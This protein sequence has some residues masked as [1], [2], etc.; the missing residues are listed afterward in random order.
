MGEGKRKQYL[1]LNGK[2]MLQHVIE[3]MFAFGATNVVVALADDDEAFG[4]IP[5][6]ERCRT[7]QGGSTRAE[8]VR[9]ALASLDVPPDSWVMVH[10]AARPCVAR[11]DIARLIETV[12]NDAVGGILAVPVVETV[13]RTAADDRITETL[14]R[15]S[16]WLAQ[17]PQMFRFGTLSRALE[18]AKSE[19]ADVTDESSAVERLGLSPLVVM[20]ARENIKVTTLSDVTLAERYLARQSA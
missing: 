4:S 13:K 9:N 14:P 5:C 18:Q 1:P 6:H 8:S 12:G 16:L 17:T 10:D 19:G 7:V 15:D 3:K 11:D 20:G 2:P